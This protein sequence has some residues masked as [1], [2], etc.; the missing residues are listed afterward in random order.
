[1]VVDRPPATARGLWVVGGGVAVARETFLNLYRI[2]KF[3]I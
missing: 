3:P 2:L 1:M